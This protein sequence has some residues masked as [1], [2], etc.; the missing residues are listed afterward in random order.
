MASLFSQ[1][2]HTHYPLAE[3]LRPRKLTDVVGQEH[4]TGSGAPL[5]ELLNSKGM[6]SFLLWG[7]PGIGKTTLARIFAKE[8]KAHF[9]AFSAVE[10]GVKDIRKIAGESEDRLNLHQEKTILFIDEIHR[11]SKSQQ[12][13]LLP[14]VERGTFY[15]IGA[16]TENPSFSLNSALLSRTRVFLLKTLD[17]SALKN[18]LQKG[19][20]EVQKKIDAEGESFL[21]RFANGDART[22]LSLLEAAAF[23][24]K[25]ETISREKLESIAQQK[26]MRFDRNGDEHYQTIS[27]FIKSMRA[28][29]AD[30]TV[31]YL[32]RLLEGGEDPRFISRRMMIFA[33]EDIG[34]ADHHALLMAHAAYKASET[35]GM[36]EVRIILSHAA[37]YLA[38]APKDNRSYRAIDMAL[39]EVRESGNLPIPLHFRPAQT[40]FLKKLGY[41]KGYAYPHTD[42]E[43]ARKVPNLPKKIEGKKF[44]EQ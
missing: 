19:L 40:E 9:E 32:A 23:Q 34:L 42:P 8:K 22:V 15:L 29:D 28:S 37:L 17:T 26:M 12:D 27:A 25:E 43:Q 5:S 1:N 6:I 35:I 41:G 3:K 11:L 39:A 18:V 14:Y 7:P 33:S 16:T 4:L 38:T 13:V 20:K 36:P 31:Y 44:F 2:R 21:L 24:T 10:Q 30:A